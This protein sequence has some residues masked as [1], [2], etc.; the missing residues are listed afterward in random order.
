MQIAPAVNARDN[1]DLDLVLPKLKL[2]AV[3]PKQIANDV[4]TK[5]SRLACEQFATIVRALR[6]EVDPYPL[7]L[8]P[9]ADGV[10]LRFFFS[11]ITL[12]QLVLHHV[13]SQWVEYGTNSAL[14]KTESA[15]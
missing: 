7:F 6:C 2:K 1:S 10:H 11:H 12:P 3:D 4:A 14:G 8:C 15:A 9:I 13:G 5:V